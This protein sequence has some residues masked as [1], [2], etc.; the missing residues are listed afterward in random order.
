MANSKRK[1]RYCKEYRKVSDMLVINGAAYC[2]HDHA[3]KY[4]IQ[5]APKARKKAEK[6]DRQRKRQD[7]QRR[8]E[9]L[10]TKPEL[11][12]ECQKAFNAY[13]RERDK[14]KPCISCGKPPNSNTNEWD[15]SHYRS[16]GA[17]P[18]LRFDPLNAH[19]SC[20]YCNQYLSGNI[21]EYRPR[22][23]DKI[24]VEQAEWIEGPHELK[25]YSIEDLKELTSKFK[26]MKEEVLL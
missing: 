1:C 24:G 16:V 3:V 21:V 13:I 10:K 4:A 5:S 22:L 18:Q 6:K 19:K 17:C 7:T 23:I 8:R 15:C 26:R 20:K 11:T 9:A 2:D 12:K 14:A 25:K